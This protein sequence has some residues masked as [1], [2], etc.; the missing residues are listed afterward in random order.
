VSQPDLDETGGLNV[1]RGI[2]VL[3]A[4][5]HCHPP[6]QFNRF[7]VGQTPDQLIARMDRTGIDVSVVM[8]ANAMTPDGQREQTMFLVDGYRKYPDRLIP[9]AFCTPMWGA[10]ALEEMRWAHSLGVRGIKLFPHGQGGF[11]ID[12][13]TLDPMMELALELGMNVVIHTDIDSK[14]CNPFL[15]LRLAARH[16]NLNFQLAHFG[17]NSDVAQYMGDWCKDSPNVYLDTAN[18]PG[19]FQFVYKAPMETMPD[20]LLFGSDGPTLYEEVEFLKIDIAQRDF[21]LTDD[22]AHKILGANAARLW[23]VDLGAWSGAQRD[24]ST[25]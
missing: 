16:P 9:V 22:E 11:A 14:V 19:N 15:G 1:R 5:T 21:G 2:F 23:G 3:D 7:L 13:P 18:S 17:L 8:S 12:S 24:R 10:Q 4:H 6:W 20:R 25:T